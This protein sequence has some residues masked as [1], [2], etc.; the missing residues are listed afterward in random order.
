MCFQIT[1]WNSFVVRLGGFFAQENCPF[2]SNSWVGSW[3]T[4]ILQILQKARSHIWGFVFFIFLSKQPA[5]L[6]TLLPGRA[7]SNRENKLSCTFLFTMILVWGDGV[8]LFLKLPNPSYKDSQFLTITI[9][10]T[11]NNIFL[12]L[13]SYHLAGFPQPWAAYRIHKTKDLQDLLVWGQFSDANSPCFT[14]LSLG[15]TELSCCSVFLVFLCYNKQGTF[16]R[17]AVKPFP[18][19]GWKIFFS[20]T[21]DCR[22]TFYFSA[23]AY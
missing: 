11:I 1:L 2:L 8:W 13:I 22:N 10:I 16:L 21:A 14:S 3:S 18:S 15:W 6:Q 7:L 20:L 23:A 4:C 19:E 5:F 9:R 12:L 17:E